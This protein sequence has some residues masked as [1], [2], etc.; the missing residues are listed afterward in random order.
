MDLF[1]A[2]EHDARHDTVEQ[3]LRSL[4]EQMAQLTIEL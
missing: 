1:G 3:Q 2:K 4:V